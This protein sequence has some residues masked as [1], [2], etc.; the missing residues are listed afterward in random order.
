[1]Y[2]FVM[3][4]MQLLSIGRLLACLTTNLQHACHPRDYILPQTC[5]TPVTPVTISYHEFA[6]YELSCCLNWSCQLIPKTQICIDALLHAYGSCMHIL[7]HTHAWLQTRIYRPACVC[8]Y[9]ECVQYEC[10]H[11]CGVCMRVRV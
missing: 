10:M 1:M 2:N 7:A 8:S 3:R 6:K 9:V 5:C 11:A 4:M